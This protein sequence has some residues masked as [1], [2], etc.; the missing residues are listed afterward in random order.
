MLSGHTGEDHY[1]LGNVFVSEANTHG[2][3]MKRVNTQNRLRVTD[4]IL[5]EELETSPFSIIVF[6]SFPSLMVDSF[7]LLR[8][9]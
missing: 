4:L 9:H 1:S 8:R 6:Q 5:P 3:V 7:F 2:E